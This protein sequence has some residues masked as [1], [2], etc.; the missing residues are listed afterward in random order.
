MHFRNINGQLRL[1]SED[2]K[3]S[4]FVMQ[5]PFEMPP[6]NSPEATDDTGKGEVST[7]VSTAASVS[8]T[9]A[10][11][12]AREGE[13]TLVDRGSIN[14]AYKYSLTPSRSFD[15]STSNG[16][17][18]SAAS[19]GS[20]KSSK[21][22]ADRLIDAIQTPLGIGEPESESTSIQRRNSKSAYYRSLQKSSSRSISPNRPLG[23]PHGPLR[24]LSSPSQVKEMGFGP[25]V[26]SDPV[27]GMEF[28]TDSKTPIR[29]IKVPDE[30]TDQPE[31]PAQSS[32]TSGVVFELGDDPAPLQHSEASQSQAASNATATD[33]NVQLTDKPRA[34][35]LQVLVA[36][37]DPI[38]M[39]ILRK[40]LEKAGHTV[41]HTVNGEDCAQ[42]YKGS[43]GDFDVVLMDMQVSYPS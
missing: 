10:P 8:T 37:D 6:N 17:L 5:L 21:S 38:N 25:V 1:K 4:R 20:V 35:K 36:E 13:V 28:I 33:G 16:S 3:G 42:A 2:G 43:S 18:R 39:K 24:S 15:G 14:S 12:R 22:D 29:P 11:T 26:E 27:V 32:E 34:T 40:R 7:A 9:L 19:R 30:Y 31:C 41:H 23:R